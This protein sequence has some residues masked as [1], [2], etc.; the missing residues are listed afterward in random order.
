M[1]EGKV[2]TESKG[3]STLCLA[4]HSGTGQQG[5]AAKADQH[6]EQECNA[7]VFTLQVT[8][9]GDFFQ[10]IKNV[11]VTK[12]SVTVSP[13]TEHSALEKVQ[14]STANHCSIFMFHKTKQ[15]SHFLGPD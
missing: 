5:R 2:I 10:F 9:L 13:G 8:F 14:T 12:N 7:C 4:A 3:M 11:C 15:H 6:G 1:V